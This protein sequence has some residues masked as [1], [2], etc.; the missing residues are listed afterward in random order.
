MMLSNL[1]FKSERE[2]LKAEPGR[3]K[4]RQWGAFLNLANNANVGEIHYEF[5]YQECPDSWAFKFG[6]N[7]YFSPFKTK[8]FKAGNP[9]LIDKE[10]IGNSR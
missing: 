7:T 8:G 2:A 4:E 6:G 5:G 3:G 1:S 10:R 9:R